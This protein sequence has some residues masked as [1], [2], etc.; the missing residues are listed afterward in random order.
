MF[1][2]N[3]TIKVDP[4]IERDW[5]T[6]QKEEYIPQMMAT[7][8]FSEFKFYK[9]LEQDEEGVIYVLQFFC[10]TA[11]QLEKFFEQYGSIMSQKAIK[12]WGDQFIAFRTTME[13]VK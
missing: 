7:S 10:N 1:V 5:L 13:T 11:A 9:L 8:L 2:Y 6:W 3:T 12:K 4:S